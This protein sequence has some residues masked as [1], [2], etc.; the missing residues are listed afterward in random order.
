MTRTIFLRCL[1]TKHIYV[2]HFATTERSLNVSLIFRSDVPKDDHSRAESKKWALSLPGEVGHTWWNNK[3]IRKQIYKTFF[4]F[5]RSW[6]CCLPCLSHQVC[7]VNPH[8]VFVLADPDVFFGSFGHVLWG[9]IETH[10]SAEL[11]GPLDHMRCVV[12]HSIQAALGPGQCHG[13]KMAQA[14]KVS[15]IFF[16]FMFTD[17]SFQFCLLLLKPY[18]VLFGLQNYHWMLFLFP[19]WIRDCFSANLNILLFRLLSNSVPSINVFCLSSILCGTM[20]SPVGW[21]CCKWYVG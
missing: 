11:L 14:L 6:N 9:D 16:M 10:T 5:P 15:G 7:H 1:F 17:L 4:A 19:L 20:F 12:Q 2:W 8:R 13:Q 18:L 21:T 3:C